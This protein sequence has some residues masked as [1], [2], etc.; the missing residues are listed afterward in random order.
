MVTYAAKLIAEATS[1]GFMDVGSALFYANIPADVLHTAPQINSIIRPGVIYAG[2]RDYPSIMQKNADFTAAKKLILV[3]DPRDALVSEYFSN[4]F[5]HNIPAAEKTSAQVNTELMMKLRSEALGMDIDRYVLNRAA[6]FVATASSFFPA[7][8]EKNTLVIK[9]EDIIF[10]KP[11][12]VDQMSHHFGL[13][14]DQNTKARISSG[15]DIRPLHED[16]QA[17][18]RQ[19]APG[20]HERKLSLKTRQALEVRLRDVLAH[21]RYA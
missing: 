7:L 3:R 15:I 2:F 8:G 9:Y 1:M 6:A 11:K 18:V 16:P 14:I 21:F 4:A 5:S 19:I 10:N 13:N 12:L 17:F 20:D